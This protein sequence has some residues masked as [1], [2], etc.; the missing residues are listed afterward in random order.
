MTRFLRTSGIAILL[1]SL[2]FQYS[3]AQELKLK[4]GTVKL[5][6]D[7]LQSFLNDPSRI[8]RE[9]SY[10]IIQ[11]KTL[12]S[13][14]Q[15]E[16][17]ANAGWELYDYI[18]D[19]AYLVKMPKEINTRSLQQLPLN[20]IVPFLP[21]YKVHP[22]VVRS[23]PEEVVVKLMPG[24]GED[25]LV[26]AGMDY[27]INR[28]YPKGY[29]EVEV[30]KEGL[31]KLAGIAEIKYIYPVPGKTKELR[32][33]SYGT[34][35]LSRL[36]SPFG[37]NLDGSGVVVGVG[38]GGN[39]GTH[40]DLNDQT[41]DLTRGNTS[42]HAAH[43]SG[44][45][46]GRGW[47]EPD[48]GLGMAPGVSML[49]QNFSDIINFAP[50]YTRD[51][52][53]LITN[54][55]YGNSLGNCSIAGD[56]NF[57]SETAD[58]QTDADQNLLH[59]FSAGNDGRNN[60]FPYEGGFG[61][62][63][64]AWQS[65]KNTLVVGNVN[66]LDVL[67]SSSSRG[68]TR[69][70]RLKPEVVGVGT[71]VL[72]TSRSNNYR[73]LSGTSM[74]GPMVAGI[75]ALL[76]EWYQREV[77]ED[78]WSALIK[79]VIANT[80][81]DLG[82]DGPDYTYGFGRVNANRALKALENEDYILDSID[83]GEIRVYDVEVT[84]S[85]KELK[86]MLY[87]HDVPAA[88]FSDP[89]LVNDLDLYVV[90]GSDTIRPLVLDPDTAHVADLAVE[91]EDHLNN[92]EQVTID[93]PANGTYRIHVRGTQVPEP[94]QSYVI[95]WSERNE[96][97]E[98]TYPFGGEIWQPGATE[99]VRWDHSLEGSASLSVYTSIDG[100]ENWILVADTLEASQVVYELRS[101]TSWTLE[102]K[103]K[104]ETNDGILVSESNEFAILPAPNNMT[105]EQLCPGFVRLHWQP[106]AG[107]DSFE[108]FKLE[109][110][111]M[112]SVGF[113]RDT[114]IDYYIGDERPWM[115]VAAH[116]N[117]FSGLRS[118]AVQTDDGGSDCPFQFDASLEEYTG[119][120][121]GRKLTSD[122]LGLEF[123]SVRVENSGTENLED[124]DIA[125]QL[126]EGPVVRE[127]FEIIMSQM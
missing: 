41:L 93:L 111:Q 24:K 14:Q 88:P 23:L 83:Q 74:S 81:D 45:I 4:S 13:R 18:P 47:L 97:L 86:I 2:A 90:F 17:L 63:L 101:P 102:A 37:E 33:L 124:V 56:Y 57:L 67:R 100:G 122:S 95:T 69:D 76:Y 40:I 125:Y 36:R 107:I 115:A 30:P 43:V 16:E 6:D 104:V 92:I 62:I 105:T 117:G 21:E 15:R 84:D 53:M 116:W 35:R 46:G 52:G 110:D 12:P 1:C 68:P 5:A 61:T 109:K 39:I 91:K 51:Y 89:V 99:F 119:K 96:G 31:M 121:F 123:V 11:F 87:W 106:L 80:S 79:S 58:V 108:I 26:Q 118:N 126:D 49:S 38:D 82:N 27:R 25:A 10:G 60:C 94:L 64:S 54:N 103:I 22:N 3:H 72:S 20:A 9:Y 120:L 127:K 42:S 70:G 77:G 8:L 55:S 113:V 75:S 71:N 78:P 32:Y 59:V 48:A 112:V 50:Q 73:T 114:T 65:S 85:P 19:N 34:Q 66:H 7:A 98:L 44:I 29:Y 28:A